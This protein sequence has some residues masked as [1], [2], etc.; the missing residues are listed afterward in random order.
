MSPGPG[1]R[2]L[3]T[4]PLAASTGSSELQGRKAPSLPWVRAE[5]SKRRWSRRRRLCERPGWG[6]NA[7]QDA[8]SPRPVPRCLR[9]DPGR[10]TNDGVHTPRGRWRGHLENIW[11]GQK[12]DLEAAKP[13]RH[14]N[15]TTKPSQEGPSCSGQVPAN[16]WNHP[17]SSKPPRGVA[18]AS[19]GRITRP[20]HQDSP[21]PGLHLPT[22]VPLPCVP[23]AVTKP[24]ACAWLQGSLG[25]QASA[26]EEVRI[27]YQLYN[28][29]SQNV[30][31][32]MNN[33][34]AYRS[35]FLCVGHSVRT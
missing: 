34:P 22:E 20:R 19:E 5:N 17:L 2:L 24:R 30:V 6:W 12:F 31:T 26:F 13:E 3:N 7:L 35:Q 11:G 18:A 33:V 14:P 23:S 21:S 16:R 25:R 8:R 10:R 4:A 32:Y 9:Q 29:W 15:Y 28:K 1:T 27:L